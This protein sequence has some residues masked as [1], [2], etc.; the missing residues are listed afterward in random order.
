MTK[1]FLA[2]YYNPELSATA[3]LYGV[4]ATEKAANEALKES[5]FDGFVTD[6]E[7]QE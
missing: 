5:G 1:V 3:I 7:V 2:W 6:E 4:Y